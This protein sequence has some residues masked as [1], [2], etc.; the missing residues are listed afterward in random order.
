MIKVTTVLF[1]IVISFYWFKFKRFI[2][3]VFCEKG[4][5]KFPEKQMQTLKN[6]LKELISL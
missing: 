1:F 3:E 6:I 4:T 2:Q 5:L